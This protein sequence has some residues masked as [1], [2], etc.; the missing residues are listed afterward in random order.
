VRP[1][2]RDYR[3]LG[4]IS[5]RAGFYFGANLGYAW[6]KS[7]ASAFVPTASNMA[8][9]G[10]ALVDGALNGG[11]RGDGLTG[12][13][14]LGWNYQAGALVL[15]VEGDFNLLDVD[16]RRS[17]GRVTSG[18]NFAEGRDRIASDWLATLRA[19]LGLA[20]AQTLFYATGGVAFT[21][22]TL[23]R[24]LDWSFVGDACPP[25]GGGMVRCHAGSE[26]FR[27][28]WTIGGGV[29]HALTRNW[30]IKAEYLYADFGSETLRTDSAGVVAN[31]WIEHRVDLN[32]HIARLGVNYKF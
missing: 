9:A 3:K 17:S 7:D 18:A 28:G 13:I 25:A 32:M 20:V 8:A 21:D 6:S 31:Q 27:V 12:G 11:T 10:R 22:A 16:G 1:R 14:A 5:K 30:T 29:E 2:V 24:S 15:G 26:Q 4:A 19:R 23:S